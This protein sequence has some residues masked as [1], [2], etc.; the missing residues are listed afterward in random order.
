M[1]TR[2]PANAL[3]CPGAIDYNVELVYQF[4]SFGDGTI[5]AWMAASDVGYTFR[6]APLRPRLGIQVNA[7]SGDDDP[8]VRDLQTFNPL[9]PQASY[10][11]DA[12]LI[13]PLNHVDVHPALALRPTDA[14]ALLLHYDTFWRESLEDGLYRTSG[15]LITTGQ[16]HSSRHVESELAL[17]VQW[18][19][20]PHAVAA[21]TH[22][23]AG[24]LPRALAELPNLTAV[25][26]RTRSGKA[27]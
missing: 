14:L 17:R 15:A 18:Q 3:R 9:F 8:L 13:G 25:R 20:D 11:S 26:L 2:R 23:F 21:Y 7:T 6:A 4:G 16:G 27:S 12:N 19:P 5:R 1:A 22:F 24:R 10:F